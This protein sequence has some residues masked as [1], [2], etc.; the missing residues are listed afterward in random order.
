[1]FVVQIG[2]VANM[3]LVDDLSGL[4]L[5]R[6]SEADVAMAPGRSCAGVSL[7]SCLSCLKHVHF[8]DA[9]QQ[10]YWCNKMIDLYVPQFIYAYASEIYYAL[11]KLYCGHAPT[12][13]KVVSIGCGAAPDLLALEKMNSEK[14]IGFEYIGIDLNEYWEPYHRVINDSSLNACVYHADICSL[15]ESLQEQLKSCDLLI[16]Q[17][18]LSAVFDKVTRRVPEEIINAIYKSVVHYM[19]EGSAVIVNDLNSDYMGRPQWDAIFSCD[20][21]N[22]TFQ[23]EDF[24]FDKK[25]ANGYT[26][27]GKVLKHYPHA[28]WTSP[29]PVCFNISDAVKSRFDPHMYCRSCFSLYRI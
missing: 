9:H 1:M 17:Y 20:G 28:F 6:F 25:S 4:A 27:Y 24:C 14:N 12:Q 29:I 19:P 8:G 16:L 13:I 5:E 26:P 15:S 23:R 10:K 2:M 11:E 22:R 3:S 18:F 7:E 21:V